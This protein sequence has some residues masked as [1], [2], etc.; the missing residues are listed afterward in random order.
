MD[1]TNDVWGRMEEFDMTPIHTSTTDNEQG[2][3]TR[4]RY[5]RD[6]HSLDRLLVHR[7][8]ELVGDE[9]PL[10]G[11][12]KNNDDIFLVNLPFTTFQSTP[13][14]THSLRH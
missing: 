6:S 1:T 14:R 7:N 5:G 8:M 4:C 13:R 2:G 12:G 11:D 9:T 10:G 3:R